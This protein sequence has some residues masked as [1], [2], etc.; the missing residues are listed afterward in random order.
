MLNT[1]MILELLRQ[2]PGRYVDHDMGQYRMKEANGDDVTITE[3][4]REYL[5][6]P[7]AE[8]MDDLTD[9]SRLVRDGSEYRLP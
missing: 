2:K 9:A 6:E 7:I 5:V 3:N 8:Q 1:T 4:G